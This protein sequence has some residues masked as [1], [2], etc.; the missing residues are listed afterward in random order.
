MKPTALQLEKINKFVLEDEAKFTFNNVEVFK[1]L[2]IDSKPTSYNTILKEGIKR[3]FIEN[4][5]NGEVA[6]MILH[7]QGE[8]LPIGKG[9]DYEYDF[10]SGTLYG[11]FY[12]PTGKTVDGL[13]H[14]VETDDI[15]T[16]IKD[17]TYSKTSMQ[18][19]SLK[20]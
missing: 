7:A 16:G 13:F 10:E 9:F 11:W 19:H 18:A 4:L 14:A 8:T 6:K 20:Y 1:A 15:I 12:I 3:A 17:G 2:L 5:K